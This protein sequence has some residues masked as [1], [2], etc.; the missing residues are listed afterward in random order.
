MRIPPDVGQVAFR[1][2]AF[3]A[4]M[5][6]LVLFWL[7]PAPESP[8]FVISVLTLALGGGLGILVGIL[9]RLSQRKH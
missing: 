6:G 7:R 3:I 1:F 9:A 4:A 8:E 5:S 2:A